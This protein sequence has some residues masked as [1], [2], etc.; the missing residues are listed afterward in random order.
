MNVVLRYIPP[1]S[2]IEKEL[3]RLQQKPETS[4]AINVYSI[5]NEQVSNDDTNDSSLSLRDQN[6]NNSSHEIFRKRKKKH[7]GNQS[8]YTPRSVSKRRQH[9]GSE[10]SKKPVKSIDLSA[11]Y[12]NKDANS[13]QTENET[14]KN[15]ACKPLTGIFFV[16]AYKS[17][18]IFRND[19]N[20][21]IESRFSRKCVE[22]GK[23]MHDLYAGRRV[24]MSTHRMSFLSKV[25]M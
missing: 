22:C 3:G 14:H 7:S 18:S 24:R 23:V 11:D 17:K 16:C 9:F 15:Y 13:Y 12:N 10:A 8:I 25:E 1:I 5:D 19:A 4:N 20:A 6:V 2:E 21:Q